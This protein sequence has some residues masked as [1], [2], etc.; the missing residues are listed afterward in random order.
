MNDL[1]WFVRPSIALILSAIDG[2]TNHVKSFTDNQHII[3]NENEK[4][5]IINEK[6]QTEK[7]N[8]DNKIAEIQAQCKKEMENLK[9]LHKKDKDVLLNSYNES[10]KKAQDI[11]EALQTRLNQTIEALGLSKTT[12]SNLKGSNKSLE[13]QISTFETETESKQE[14]YIDLKTEN[15]SLREKLERSIELNNTLSN[16]EKQYDGQIKQLQVKCSQ[17]ISLTKKGANT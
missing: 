13:Q 10:I 14:K 11:N 9:L 6:F 16:R 2:L 8:F 4:L 15:A 7:T 3:L 1:T 5:K 17:L 12:I